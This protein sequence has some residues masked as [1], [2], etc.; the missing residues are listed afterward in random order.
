MINYQNPD[1]DY[2]RYFARSTSI[3]AWMGVEFWSVG[4][5][6]WVGYVIRRP[7]EVGASV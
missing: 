6:F 3:R 5:K 7:G 4:K 2:Q 1:E